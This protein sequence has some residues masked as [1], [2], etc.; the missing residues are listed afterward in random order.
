[1]AKKN[2]N[3]RNRKI[4]SNA[5]FR[6]D[7]NPERQEKINE[8]KFASSHRNFDRAIILLED[9]LK[10]YPDDVYML[11]FQS[12]IY[13]KIKQVDK[14][15][16]ILLNVL[17]R[18]LNNRELSFARITY[19]RYLRFTGNY[20][21]ALELYITLINESNSIE[22]VARRDLTE[23]CIHLKKYEI[24]LKYLD[25]K[26]FNNQYLNNLRC[27]LYLSMREYYKALKELDR[28]YIDKGTI[29]ITEN[30][31]DSIINQDRD[32][33]RGHIYFNIRKNDLA[34]EY[35]EKALSNK[36]RKTYYLSIIDLAKIK[37]S[38]GDSDA[39]ISLCEDALKRANNESNFIKDLKRTLSFAYKSNNNFKKALSVY[40]DENDVEI[41]SGMGLSRIYYSKGDFEK[42]EKEIV[43]TPP[44]S[45][46]VINFMEYYNVAAIKYRLGK[47]DEANKYI[48]KL[49][50]H[51][52]LLIKYKL[53]FFVHRLKLLIDLDSNEKIEDRDF[54][55]SEL[56]MINYDKDKAIEHIID[57]HILNDSYSNFSDDIDIEQLFEEV[58]KR[59]DE[60]I[61]IYCDS[62]D[63]YILKYDN[64]GYFDNKVINQL[65][66]IVV[67][68]TKNIITMYPCKNILN[69]DIEEDI[70]PKKEVKRLSQIE[71]FNLK[72]G[73][74]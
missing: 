43:L 45:V 6:Q 4:K 34:E 58:Q 73:I 3:F 72:Y 48:D 31:D 36:Y 65:E 70:K 2:R 54:T 15:K 20:E 38:R 40:D 13:G 66:I 28:K 30:F 60:A 59:L 17:S 56:Q 50:M 18:N 71:K 62:V 44:N 69:T 11:I 67:P 5:R 74:K 29:Q 46:G 52:D 47:Y 23:L 24:A 10:E 64:I 9:Y 61:I 57:H 25:I 68:K 16:E 1:M 35:L 39:A 53:S 55:Y 63:K 12:S 32:Y 42:A 22:L 19:G 49:L 41:Q 14:E 21:E 51:E 33:Y 7:N 8:I 26:N 27:E 37:I